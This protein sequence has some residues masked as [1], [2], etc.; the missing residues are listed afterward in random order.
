MREEWEYGNNYLTIYKRNAAMCR[1]IYASL[2]AIS[3]LLLMVNRRCAMVK[4]RG[5]K[6]GVFVGGGWWGGGGGGGGLTWTLM[7]R[8]FRMVSITFFFLE[9]GGGGVA[10]NISEIL[11][12]KCSS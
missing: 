1:C 7:L 3:F 6:M 11:H 5:R 12:Y 9:G 4:G 8:N 2:C 10:L